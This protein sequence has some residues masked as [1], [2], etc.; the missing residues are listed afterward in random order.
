M[1]VVTAAAIA[2]VYLN[3]SY[4]DPGLSM[5]VMFGVLLGSFL[6]THVLLIARTRLLRIII[7]L[8]IFALALEMLYNGITGRL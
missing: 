7:G 2:G 3:R 5:P 8:V 1:I 4:I 6:G